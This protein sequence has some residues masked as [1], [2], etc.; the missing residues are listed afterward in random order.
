V[1]E[2]RILATQPFLIFNNCRLLIAHHTLPY[3][4]ADVH[5]NHCYRQMVAHSPANLHADELSTSKLFQFILSNCTFAGGGSLPE[6][7]STKH[8]IELQFLYK[9]NA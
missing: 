1:V 5:L 7:F 6:D 9:L 4:N 8:A 2:Q 3:S